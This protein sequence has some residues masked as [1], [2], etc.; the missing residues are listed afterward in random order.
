[1]FKAQDLAETSEPEEETAGL[2][3]S[4]YNSIGFSYGN[5][6]EVQPPSTSVPSKEEASIEPYTP[7]FEGI[8]EDLQLPSSMQMH[9]VRSV[10]VETERLIAMFKHQR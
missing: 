9:R 5:T 3:R 7:P 1:M 6:E 4:A 10:T 2:T 8:P